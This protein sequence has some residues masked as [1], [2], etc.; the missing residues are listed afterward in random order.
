MTGDGPI[1]NLLIQITPVGELHAPAARV[2]KV[3]TKS[4]KPLLP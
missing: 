2:E 3:A 1:Q 4:M